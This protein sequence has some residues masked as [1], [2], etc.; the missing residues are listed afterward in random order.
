MSLNFN[1][2]K[3]NDQAEKFIKLNFRM[4]YLNANMLNVNNKSYN[5]TI[6]FIVYYLLNEC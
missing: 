6:D 4:I 1:F 3:L 5:R 2:I